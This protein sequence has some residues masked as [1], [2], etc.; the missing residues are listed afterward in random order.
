MEEANKLENAEEI[1]E[2]PISYEER[3]KK[4]G[5]EEGRQEVAINM[6]RKGLDVQFVSETT[7]LSLKEITE[8]KKNLESE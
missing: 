2:L 4:I 6:L 5:R 8:L 3:G 7:E 1:L